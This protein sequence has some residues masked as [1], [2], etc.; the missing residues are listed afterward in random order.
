MLYLSFPPPIP[1]YMHTFYK[2]AVK[3]KT[4][5]STEQRSSVLVF[6][7][8]LISLVSSVITCNMLLPAPLCTGTQ[9]FSHGFWNIA[10]LSSSD[11]Q[12]NS[13]SLALLLALRRGNAQITTVLTWMGSSCLFHQ[14][15]SIY[16]WLE[17]LDFLVSS[18]APS[19]H[20][21]ILIVPEH[22]L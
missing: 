1:K 6:A 22:Q 9:I 19:W 14:V 12:S 5:N 15:M 18:T 13:S 3:W 10:E 7:C 16:H 17:P 21:M 20:T 11:Q 8:D 2:T 4:S